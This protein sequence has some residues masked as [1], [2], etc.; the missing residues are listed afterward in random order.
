MSSRHKALWDV[1][2]PDARIVHYTTYKPGNSREEDMLA[3]IDHPYAEIWGVN[4]D[5]QEPL[6]WWWDAYDAMSS[7]IKY[8]G[9]GQL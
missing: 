8:T 3:V 4:K 1:A 9:L 6:G 7:A 5:L 2:K